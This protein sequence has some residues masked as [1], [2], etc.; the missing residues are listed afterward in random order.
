MLPAIAFALVIQGST[1]SL[2]EL[3]KSFTNASKADA[4][5]YSALLEINRTVFGMIDANTLQSPKEFLRACNLVSDFRMK[6][7]TSRVRHELCLV[8]L[9]GGEAGA[10]KEIKKTWDYLL[11]STGRAQRI[12]TVPS[13]D[14]KKAETIRAPKSIWNVISDPDKASLLAAKSKSDAEVTKLCADDQADREKDWSKMS[15]KEVEGIAARDEA[16]LRRVKKLLEAGR[17]VTAEDFDHAS[18]VLQ[19]GAT[20]NDYSLAHELSICSLLLGNMKAA[21]LTAASYDR[22]LGSA[23]YR[24]RFGTQYGSIGGLPFTFDPYDTSAINDAERKIMRCPT[25]EKA[26]NRKW[27]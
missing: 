16:R 5:N 23:G 24:Q 18:L 6:Y 13:Q 1:M 14:E 21:W 2:D 11:M 3:E 25:L 7:E 15:M 26:M 19:H 27:N 8:A 20:W 10:R 9:A 17:V 4:Y 12:G 22:M